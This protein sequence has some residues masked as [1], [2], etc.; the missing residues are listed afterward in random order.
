[1]LHKFEHCCYDAFS[2]SKY[3]AGRPHEATLWR[4]RLELEGHVGLAD[5]LDPNRAPDLLPRFIWE[6]KLGGRVEAEAA[7]GG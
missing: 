3:A 6:V 5:V 2:W 4:C 7:P 1:M